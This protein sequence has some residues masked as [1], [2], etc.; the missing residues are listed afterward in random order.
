MSLRQLLLSLVVQPTE[1]N[2][3]IADHLAATSE[4]RMDDLCSLRATCREMRCVCNNE[5]IR[6]CVALGRFAFELQWSDRK[7]YDAYS[8]A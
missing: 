3:N 4:R 8:I 5:A 1:V 7:G 2:I 6:L